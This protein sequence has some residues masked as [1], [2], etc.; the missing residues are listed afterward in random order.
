MPEAQAQQQDETQTPLLLTESSS[1]QGVFF[2]EIFI[3]LGVEIILPLGFIT[4]LSYIFDEGNRFIAISP[5]PFWLVV[6]PVAALHGLKNGLICAFV[7]TLFLLVGNIP[8]QQLNEDMYTYFFRLVHNPLLWFVAA[9]VLGEVRSRQIQEV[10]DWKHLFLQ[11]EEDKRILEKAFENQKKIKDA[12]E[13]RIAA[14]LRTP[15][16]SLNVA[17][18]LIQTTPDNVISQFITEIEDFIAPD[19]FSIFVIEGAGLTLHYSHNWSQKD[20]FKERFSL[21]SP[22]YIRMVKAKKDVCVFN[23]DEELI[24]NNQGVLAVPLVD[25]LLNETFAMVKFEHLAF[26]DLNLS[27]IETIRELCKCAS[28]AYVLSLEVM[29]ALQPESDGEAPSP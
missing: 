17:R 29:K 13:I 11:E 2:K 8:E 15:A 12:L 9:F 28:Q 25:P 20:S 26:R 23:A 19:K 6:L 4:I 18:M 14:E 10:K 27:N 1:K 22:L 3:P 5:H 7:A 24:L 16:R 21:E